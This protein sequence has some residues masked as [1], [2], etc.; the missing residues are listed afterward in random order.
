MQ[1]KYKE[2]VIFLCASKKQLENEKKIHFLALRTGEKQINWHDTCWYLCARSAASM[3]ERG[4]L[5]WRGWKRGWLQGGRVGELWV[6]W[7]IDLRRV[8]IECSFVQ[9]AE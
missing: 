7:V 9:P 4:S 8:L 6:S 1:D 3:R 2:L 5:L